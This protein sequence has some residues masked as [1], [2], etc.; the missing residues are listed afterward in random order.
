[1]W[2]IEKT[3]NCG[4][5]LYAV[6]PNHPKA[7]NG[8]YV[9]MHRIVMENHLNRL[10]T[11]TEV[12][13]HKDHNPRNNDISNLEVLDYKKHVQL[14]VHARGRKTVKLK[15]PWCGKEFIKY[16]NATHLNKPSKYNCTCCSPTCRGKLYRYIQMH[17]ISDEIQNKIDNN[18]IKTFNKYIEN[19]N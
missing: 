15:C 9:L 19:N 18:I 2:N 6:V 8:R 3:I 1:M 16:F 7:T 4:K 11:D 17:G 14:H 5:Y 10:L 12:V 13:H